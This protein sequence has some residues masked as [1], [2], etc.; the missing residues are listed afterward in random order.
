MSFLF[1][2]SLLIGPVVLDP[3][4]ANIYLTVSDNLTRVWNEFEIT[5]PIPDNLERFDRC[6]CVLGSVGFST[7]MHT[8]VSPQSLSKEKEPTACPM[9][10]GVSDLKM[11]FLVS[12]IL[13]SHTSHYLDLRNQRQW[14]WSWT[15]VQ[16]G[17]H[18]QIF[19][20]RMSITPS[21]TISL[22]PSF[23]SS[24]QF[25]STLS[26]FCLGSSLKRSEEKNVGC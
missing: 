24:S 18:S 8:W 1:W 12:Q 10:S 23:H 4:T 13:W 15:W 6:P 22:R 20:A 7:G 11:K 9:E 17:C 2:N 21:H 5:E 25:A 14:G 16:G 19:C 26:L 3:N